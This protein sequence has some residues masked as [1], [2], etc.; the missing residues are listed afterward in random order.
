MWADKETETDLLGFDVLVDELIVALTTKSLHPLTIGVLGSWGSGKSSLLAITMAELERESGKYACVAFS[1]W[2]YEDV[3]DVKTALMTAVLTKCQEFAPDEAAKGRIERLR[4]RLPR[5]GRRVGTFAATVAPAALPAVLTMVDPSMGV[6]AAGAAQGVVQVGAEMAKAAIR[7]DPAPAPGAKAPGSVDSIR[8]FRDELDEV[9]DSLPIDAVVVFIDDLDRCLP[10]TVI[11]TFEALRLFLQTPKTAHVVAV[12]R[13]IVEA[14]IDSRYP[15]FRREDGTGIGHEYLEKMLQLQVRVPQ[16][17]GV[18]VETYVNLLLTQSR[19]DPTRFK[20]LIA[21]LRTRRR[22]IAI[23]PAYNA[24]IAAQLLGEDLTAE[25]AA[26]LAW[27][28]DIC[29]VAAAGLRGNPRQLKRFLNDLTLRMRAAARREIELR[30]NVLAKLMVLDE[31]FPD[32]FQQLFDWQHRAAGPSP[33]LKLAEELALGLTRLS[34]D[35][36][37]QDAPKKQPA[38]RKA[39]GGKKPSAAPS[40]TAGDGD[41]EESDASQGQAVDP[42]LEAAANQWAT[43]QRLAFWLRLEPQLGELDLRMYFSYFRDRIV[44]GSIASTLDAKLQILL[45]R[46]VQEENS[47]HR[48][49]AIDEVGALKETEQDAFIAAVLE[50]AT[51]TPDSNAFRAAS[52]IGG[53]HPRLGPAVC[54]SFRAI[55]HQTLAPGRIVGAL[56]QLKEADGWDVLLE[57]WKASPVKAVASMAG[58]AGSGSRGR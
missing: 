49:E 15:D 50:V 22:G 46:I 9:L 31:Q 6:E 43:R 36:A 34:M 27:G 44:I 17:S 39:A 13:D 26:D 4:E 16:L 7:E 1:P 42:I 41:G 2:Q 55:P 20:E 14:A 18:D 47:R 24:G 12:S 54:E 32:D 23:P 28:S 52:E 10:P 48:R 53:R 8:A 25:L 19:L 29:E 35:S 45:G 51:R 3:A 11:D 5:F 38:T 56:A 33:E 30:P 57:T 40:R 58:M 21:A 37:A